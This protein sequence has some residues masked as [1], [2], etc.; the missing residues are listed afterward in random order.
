MMNRRE[1]ERENTL[2]L[3]NC[4]VILVNMISIYSISMDDID[5]LKYIEKVMKNCI[6]R[7]DMIDL[8]DNH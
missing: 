3:I 4:V 7:Q 8:L 2:D 6:D 5:R 1:L